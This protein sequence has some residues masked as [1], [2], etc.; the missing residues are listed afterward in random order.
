MCENIGNSLLQTKGWCQIDFMGF[1]C[2]FCCSQRSNLKISSLNY[3]QPVKVWQ[4]QSATA[5]VMKTGSCCTLT[6]IVPPNGDAAVLARCLLRTG[7]FLINPRQTTAG[8]KLFS[9]WLTG[10][11]KSLVKPCRALWSH[12]LNVDPLTLKRCDWKTQT[13]SID[14]SSSNDEAPHKTPFYCWKSRAFYQYW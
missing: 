13:F 11:G 1:L 10:F 5:R 7:H 2:V 6:Q 8:K 12:T 3:F 9:L 4:D 14:S